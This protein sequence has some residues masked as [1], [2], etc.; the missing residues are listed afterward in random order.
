MMKVFPRND[1]DALKQKMKQLAATDDRHG[2]PRPTT[3]SASHQSQSLSLSR[4]KHNPASQLCTS[5]LLLSLLLFHLISIY[6]LVHLMLTSSGGNVFR[7][8]TLQQLFL[9]LT[10]SCR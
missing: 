7:S 8:P 6:L 9:F 10:R 5:V 3:I 4:P 1:N 2:Q